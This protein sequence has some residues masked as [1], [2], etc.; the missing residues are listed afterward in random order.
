MNRKS[1]KRYGDDVEGEKIK[2]LLSACNR[3][4]S[5]AYSLEEKVRTDHSRGPESMTKI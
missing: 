1:G 3:K 2:T 5:S 4:T